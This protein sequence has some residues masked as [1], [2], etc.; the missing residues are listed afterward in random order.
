MCIQR[1]GCMSVRHEGCFG[2]INRKPLVGDD[3]VMDV[4]DPEEK[5][6]NIVE[7]LERKSE[8]I[9]P[10]VANVDQA[11]VIFAVMNPEPNFNLLDRFLILM[12]QQGLPCVICFNKADLDQEGKA[13]EAYEIYK[14]SGCKILVFSAKEGKGT[15]RAGGFAEG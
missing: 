10:A 2:R 14:N 9:R 12:A 3:V 5:K 13:Q 11:L 4:V 15:E 8:L 6:G 7:L 1:M